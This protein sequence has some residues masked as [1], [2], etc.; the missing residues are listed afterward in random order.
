MLLLLQTEGK[1]PFPLHDSRHSE[2]LIPERAVSKWNK[3]F[4]GS[5]NY[6]SRMDTLYI[7]H[8]RLKV[9]KGYIFIKHR[10][11]INEP[12][13]SFCSCQGGLFFACENF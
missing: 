9:E 6:A 13:V 10:W 7:V 8:Q 3:M 2:N 11:P 5:V 1:F 4:T 12:M